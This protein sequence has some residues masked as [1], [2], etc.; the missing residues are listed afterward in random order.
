MKISCTHRLLITYSHWN[1]MFI[2]ST[3]LP[4]LKTIRLLNSFLLVKWYF[5]VWFSLL[6]FWLLYIFL[7]IHILYL[8]PTFLLS[9]LVFS[10]LIFRWSIVFCVYWQYWCLNSGLCDHKAGA[11]MLEPCLSLLSISSSYT[12]T[13]SANCGKNIKGKFLIMYRP[14]FCPFPNITV[15]Q[16]FMSHL[17]CIG[18]CKSFGNYLK[19]TER[20]A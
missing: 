3:S 16:P 4:G 6:F 17:H 2:F 1:L 11:L 13:Y 12:F 5:F 14:F 9:H 20:C 10:T 8:S 15:S 18:Y 19:P 7:P